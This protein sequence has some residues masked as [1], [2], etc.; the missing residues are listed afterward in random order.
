MSREISQF[1]RGRHGEAIEESYRFCMRPVLSNVDE[2]LDL[3]KYL[4]C[5][6][7]EA[8]EFYAKMC[9]KTFPYTYARLAQ[10]EL[11]PPGAPEPGPL[12]D[13]D[14]IR[15]ITDIAVEEPAEVPELGAPSK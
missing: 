14:D 7:L 15:E 5:S 6:R 8:A 12:F 3:A 10:V 13:L 9:E 2:L 4:Q 1:L 11:C